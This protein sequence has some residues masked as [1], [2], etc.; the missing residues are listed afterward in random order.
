MGCGQCEQQAAPGATHPAGGGFPPRLH[1]RAAEM[2][3]LAHKWRSVC[4]LILSRLPVLPH[5][6][7]QSLYERCYVI[8]ICHGNPPG[9]SDSQATVAVSGPVSMVQASNPGPNVHQ[10]RGM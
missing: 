10:I 6:P 5:V 9:R 8:A 7:R 3:S 2:W 4:S 1:E